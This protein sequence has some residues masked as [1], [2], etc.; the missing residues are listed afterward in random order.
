[1]RPE[2]RYTQAG[3]VSLAYQI[4]GNGPIDL[5]MAPGWIFHIE[6]GWEQPE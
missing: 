3:D 6:V 5:V 1:M 4:L 2:T